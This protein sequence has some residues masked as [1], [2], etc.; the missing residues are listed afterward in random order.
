MYAGL[1]ITL[2]TT[3]RKLRLSMQFTPPHHCAML[4]NTFHV[5]HVFKPVEKLF[6]TDFTGGKNSDGHETVTDL[7]LKESFCKY[8][9][10]GKSLLKKGKERLWFG[11]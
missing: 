11:I 6:R 7:K 4:R 10:T 9:L 5:R 8:G 3:V 2:I 1:S